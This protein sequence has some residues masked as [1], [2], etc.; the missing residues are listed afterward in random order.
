MGSINHTGGF[1]YEKV[2]LG[3]LFS[4]DGCALVVL[5]GAS[6]DLACTSS[7]LVDKHEQRVGCVETIL[8]SKGERG[9]NNRNLKNTG[10]E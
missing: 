10:C 6:H 4:D 8:R 9:I 7:V 5:E 2:E 1:G 3:L